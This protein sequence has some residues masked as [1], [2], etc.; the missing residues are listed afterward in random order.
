MCKQILNNNM[1]CLNSDLRYIEIGSKIFQSIT[2]A[3][4]ELLPFPTFGP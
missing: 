1:I 2:M 3:N 4:I